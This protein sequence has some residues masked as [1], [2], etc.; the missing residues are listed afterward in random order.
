MAHENTKMEI[1][2]SEIKP[3]IMRCKKKPKKTN[4]QKKQ[5]NRHRKLK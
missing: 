4:K 1:Y 3:E 5:Q 2:T